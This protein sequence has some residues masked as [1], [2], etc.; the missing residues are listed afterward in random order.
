MIPQLFGNV[1]NPVIGVNQQQQPAGGGN[2]LFEAFFPQV[3][4]A[5]EG[6]AYFANLRPQRRAQLQQE[7]V[8]WDFFWLNANLAVNRQVYSSPGSSHWNGLPLDNLAG[9]EYNRIPAGVHVSVY[10]LVIPHVKT[11][12]GEQDREDEE[13]QQ[14][15]AEEEEEE[16]GQE[17]GFATP[18]QAPRAPVE[19][20]EPEGRALARV[21]RL[22]GLRR[23]L[24][25]E[26]ERGGSAPSAKKKR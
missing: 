10:Q 4:E 26:E 9:E 14:E 2:L 19:A 18:I 13:E 15:R 25:F 12:Q 17:E 3:R 20:P 6:G 5:F 16:E 7:L 23:Q 1:P 8:I 22:R 11:M 24:Q 21:Q